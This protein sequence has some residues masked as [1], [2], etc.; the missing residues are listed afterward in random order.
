MIQINIYINRNG[1]TD[2]DNKIVV[3][4]VG[5]GGQGA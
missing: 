4:K 2:I 5:R 3:V 1:P